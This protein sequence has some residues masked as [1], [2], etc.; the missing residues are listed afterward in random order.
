MPKKPK[1]RNETVASLQ[2]GDKTDLIVFDDKTDGFGFRLRLSHDGK[3]VMRQWI[4]QYKRSGR[5]SRIRLGDFPAKSAEAARKEAEKLRGRIAAG[6]DPAADRRDRRA[7]D[8][9]TMRSVVTEFLAAKEPDYA[10]RSFTEATRYLTDK[11]Y[12][13]G[14]HSRPLDAI[15]LRDIAAAIT[16]IKRESGPATAQR[17]RGCLITFFSWAVRQGLVKANPC[18]GSENPETKSRDRVLDGAELVRIWKACGDD[19]YGK[20]IRLLI[21]TG[22]RRAEIGDAAWSWI[23]REKGTL[24][25]PKTVAKT[26]K[27]RVIPLLPMLRDIIKDVPRM[28]SRDQLFGERSHG[29]SSWALHKGPLDA[30]AKVTDWVVH[31]LRRSV[32]THMAEELAVQPHIVELV[33]GHEFRTGVQA[34]YNRAP[35]EAPIRDAY[36]RWHDYLKTL[37]D[38]GRRKLIPMPNIAS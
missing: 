2:L 11:R 14:L 20:I 25:I 3:R 32:A 7:K 35:Y 23:D 34:R 5:T 30:R 16:R 24:T 6:E 10:P 18:I 27:A 21:L 37:L 19:H 9:V 8:A 12:F 29:F 38:G 17:S 28:A 33:L 31:D 15:E 26:G 4:F 1:L 13:G 36:L 22:C